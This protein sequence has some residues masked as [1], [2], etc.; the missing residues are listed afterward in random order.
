[1]NTAI[2]TGINAA[3]KLGDK[4][5]KNLM[6]I[7]KTKKG[8]NFAKTAGKKNSSLKCRGYWRFDWKQNS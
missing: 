3:R 6:D 5:G 8:T 7:A 4:Y 2:K 1:M